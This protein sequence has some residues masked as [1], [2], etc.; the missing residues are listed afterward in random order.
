MRRASQLPHPTH[1]GWEGFRLPRAIMRPSNKPFALVEDARA[2]APGKDKFGPDIPAGALS[3]CNSWERTDVYWRRTGRYCS[4]CASC[5]V[6]DGADI[7]HLATAL[8]GLPWA[9]RGRRAWR[10]PV[11]FAETRLLASFLGC[12]WRLARGENRDGA[13]IAVTGNSWSILYRIAPG[14]HPMVRGR[15]CSARRRS[16]GRSHDAAAGKLSSRIHEVC[17][18]RL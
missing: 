7:A 6:S 17:P 10:A 13:L 14:M 9:T 8:R 4:C 2:G 3:Y 15:R 1:D 11:H 12:A 18:C 16:S 5:P